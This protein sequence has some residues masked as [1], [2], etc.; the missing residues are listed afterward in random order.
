MSAARALGQIGE[1]IPKVVDVGDGVLLLLLVELEVRVD[2][3]LEVELVELVDVEL[4]VELDG[5]AVLSSALHTLRLATCVTPVRDASTATS[6][7]RSRFAALRSV[8]QSSAVADG[9]DAADTPTANTS[10]P[11]PN[12]AAPPRLSNWL[13]VDASIKTRVT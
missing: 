5:D 2:T 3:V 7:T 9:E 6:S 8:S 12:T 1:M 11:L 13:L 4:V 10:I